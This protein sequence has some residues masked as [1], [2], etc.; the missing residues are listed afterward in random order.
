[1][2]E[3]TSHYQPGSESEVFD[4][5]NALE[6]RMSHVNSAVSMAT[7]KVFLHHTLNMTATHQQVRGTG[8]GWRLVSTGNPMSK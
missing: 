3:L 4:I 1:M 8:P 2:L 5:L 6:D 7:I